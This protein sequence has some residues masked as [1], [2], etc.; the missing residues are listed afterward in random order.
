VAARQAPQTPQRE[1]YKPRQQ[2]Q[3]LAATEANPPVAQEIDNER[4]QQRQREPGDAVGDADHPP[5]ALQGGQ[6]GSQSL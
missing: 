3:P 6:L 4:R 2:R 1:D 5:L